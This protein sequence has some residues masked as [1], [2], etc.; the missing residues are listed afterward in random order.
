MV[1]SVG[2]RNWEAK[3][4][5]NF[6]YDRW[7]YRSALQETPQIAALSG[8]LKAGPR[9]ISQLRGKYWAKD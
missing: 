4:Q 8:V 2:K 1:S 9:S 3:E 7:R 6:N 5:R